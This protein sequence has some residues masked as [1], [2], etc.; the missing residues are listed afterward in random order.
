ML[1]L[2]GFTKKELENDSREVEILKDEAICNKYKKSIAKGLELE[3]R[4]PVNSLS[5]DGIAQMLVE[6]I[7]EA[8]KESI[9]LKERKT[10]KWISEQILELGQHT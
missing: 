3:K 4:K 1:R 10:R 6:V 5:I 9:L 8:V 7:Y 2:K